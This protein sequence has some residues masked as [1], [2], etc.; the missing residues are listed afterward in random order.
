MHTFLDLH[1]TLYL[2]IDRAKANFDRAWK[3]KS[4]SSNISDH[5]YIHKTFNK[6]KVKQD[7]NHDKILIKIWVKLDT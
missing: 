2:M 4:S 3:K 6:V 7:N 5:N 1:N